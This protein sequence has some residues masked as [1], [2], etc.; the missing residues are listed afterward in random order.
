MRKIEIELADATYEGV[1]RLAA[2][3]RVSIGETARTLVETGLRLNDLRDS[4]EGEARSPREARH[5][6]PTAEETTP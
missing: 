3:S 1:D 5:H 2:R 4:Y 6:Q